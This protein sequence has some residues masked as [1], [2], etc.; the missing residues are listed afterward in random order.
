MK[1][2]FLLLIL[3]CGLPFVT[4]LQAAAPVAGY[5]EVRS[6]RVSE[7]KMHKIQRFWKKI[8]RHSTATDLP[9]RLLWTGLFGLGLALCISLFSVSLGGI[10]AAAALACLII[11]GIFKLGTL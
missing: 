1:K 7:K 3:L 8:T 11:G 6:I 9:D 5:A 10:V 4:G 2:R